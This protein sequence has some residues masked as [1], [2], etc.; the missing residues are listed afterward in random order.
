MKKMG[1]DIFLDV[2][3]VLFSFV[4][5]YYAYLNL[6]TPPEK[7]P[8]LSAADDIAK[9]VIYLYPE[10]EETVTVRLDYPG[11]IYVSY[12]KY[13]PVL[14]GWNVKAFPGGKIVN[15][16]DGN[17]YSYL[18]WEGREASVAWDLSEGFIVEGEK[19]DIFLRDIL[20]RMGLTPREY[21]EFIV[22]WYP[23][24]KENKYNLVHFAKGE[25]EKLAPLTVEP[26]PDSILRV[27][28]VYKPLME[29]I[30]IQPQQITP[31]VRSGFAVVEWGGTRI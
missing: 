15:L 22:Y 25:Y 28:M 23:R 27:F 21:N 9:P 7:S 2:L 5:F 4:L 31:F 6:I 29:K 26:R 30:D 19:A 10:T 11:E 3:L 16:A 20:A 8:V 14:K 18:F 1:I 12:P 17:E 24:L 13:D